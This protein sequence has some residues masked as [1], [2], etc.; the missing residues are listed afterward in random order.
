MNDIPEPV[1]AERMTR[2]Q[3]FRVMELLARARELEEQGRSIV[4]MEVGEP[5]FDTPAPVV[6]A[7]RRALSD[8]RTHYT[9]AR[10]L[11]QLRRAIAE[12]YGRQFTLDVDP[13]RILVTP[14]ASGALQLV[15]ATLDNPDAEVLMTDPGYPCNRNFVHLVDA[16]PVAVPVAAR[17]GYQPTARQLGEYWSARTAAVLLASPSNPTGTM[18]DSGELD[19][20]HQHAVHHGVHVILDEIYQGLT[21]GTGS[22]SALAVADDIFVINSFSKYFGMTGWR[23]GW[24]VAPADYVPALDKLAQNLFL[25]APTPAQYAALAAFEPATLEILEARRQEFQRRRDYLVPALQEIGFDVPVTPDGAFYV[26][27]GCSRFTDDSFGFCRELLERI[28]VALT[29]GTDFG[30][31]HAR[32]QVR[33]AYTTSMEKLEEGVRRLGEALA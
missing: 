10:G 21:Y 30:T 20:I 18:L 22:T 2:I 8:G 26:Y 15:L 16:V 7:G 28:G 3:P 29:P 24:V 14:G 23:L 32:R 6:E 9:P 25:S 31:H 5:D 33:F 19:A 11:A 27:A 12:F 17:T 13:D 4:H 1:V